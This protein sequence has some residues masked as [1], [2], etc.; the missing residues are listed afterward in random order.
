[1]MIKE[2]VKAAE[3]KTTKVDP[4]TTNA[5]DADLPQHTNTSLE[6]PK[7]P[8]YFKV[9]FLCFLHRAL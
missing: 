5:S 7:G 3:G 8:N 9:F 1:M 4:Q 6:K 2:K